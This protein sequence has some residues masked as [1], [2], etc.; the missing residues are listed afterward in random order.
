[1][2]TPGVAAVAACNGIAAVAAIAE[3]TQEQVDADNRKI[4]DF[5]AAIAKTN[6]ILLQHIEQKDVRALYGYDS[7]AAKWQKL[8]ADY[9]K[10][11]TQMATEARARFFS[12]KWGSPENTL[13]LQHR[14]GAAYSELEIQGVPET[15]ETQA[16]VLMTYP[17]ERW[18]SFVDTISMR[19]P[20]PTVA[21]I[22][23]GMKIIEERQNVRDEA[24]HGEANYA[25]RFVGGYR[26]AGGGG[27]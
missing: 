25:R 5:E 3:I 19:M 2:I 26:G 9:A 24:E 14:F 8:Q 20:P 4:E 10:I 17:T 18:R 1:M 27:H 22:F 12:F 6:Y 16:R 11:S 13:E 21:D 7:R 23:A 15:P